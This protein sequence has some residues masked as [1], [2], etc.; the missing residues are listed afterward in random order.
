MYQIASIQTGRCVACGRTTEVLAVTP[1]DR[2]GKL[3]LLCW[4]DLRRQLRIAQAPAESAT[5]DLN[6]T[7]SEK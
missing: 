7:L 3:L 4:P 5:G 1:A 6:S 2:N